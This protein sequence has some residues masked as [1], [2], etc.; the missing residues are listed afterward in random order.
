MITIK[1]HISQ[2]KIFFILFFLFII[3]GAIDTS[4]NGREASLILLNRYNN[5]VFDKL[6]YILT[7]LGDGLSSLL[8][9]L[10]LTFIN[11]RKSLLVLISFLLSGLL[12]QVIKHIVELPRPMGLISHEVFGKL[13]QVLPISD[14]YTANSFPS[15]HSATAFSL[16]LLLALFSKSRLVGAF[17]FIIAF[18]IGVSR[19]YLLQHFFTDVWAGT[20]IGVIST[21]ICE[22]YIIR[23]NSEKHKWPDSN[24]MKSF[25]GRRK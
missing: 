23:L 10:I 20:V 3:A 9:V 2:N 18:M 12:V 8:V 11:Y 15:G 25:G 19:V 14:I 16:F 1:Q 13:H 4:V 6:F 22:H 7:W 17:C 24:L 5:P 21:L